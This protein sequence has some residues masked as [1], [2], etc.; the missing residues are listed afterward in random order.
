MAKLND[1]KICLGEF[2]T[3]K[4]FKFK[5][6]IIPENTGIIHAENIKTTFGPLFGQIP[7]SIRNKLIKGTFIDNHLFYFI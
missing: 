1:F 2:I 7:N 4:E 6:S 3:E 5:K